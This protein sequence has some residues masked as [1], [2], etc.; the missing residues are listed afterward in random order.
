M[1]NSA[2]CAVAMLVFIALV[3]AAMSCVLI[4]R[5]TPLPTTMPATAPLSL[6]TQG[7]E[8]STA[9]ASPTPLAGPEELPTK[10]SPE[11]KVMLAVFCD[12]I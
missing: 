1:K 9:A 10:G 6:S 4:P 11:A 8:V 7:T 5:A 3:W 2:R 12:F